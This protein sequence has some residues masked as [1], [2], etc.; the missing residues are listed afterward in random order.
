MGNKPKAYISLALGRHLQM[1][2]E[3]NFVK[4]YT[5]THTEKKGKRESKDKLKLSMKY[6]KNDSLVTNYL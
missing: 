4:Y 1:T 6:F 3:W 5:I 2:G